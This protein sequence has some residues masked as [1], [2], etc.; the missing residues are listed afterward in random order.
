MPG[1]CEE[2]LSRISLYLD[3]ELAEHLC[4]ELERHLAECPDCHVVFHTT[5]RTIELYRRYGRT[6][7]PAEA[8]ERLF[9]VLRL[10]DLLSRGRPGPRR[11]PVN[12]IQRLNPRTALQPSEMRMKPPATLRVPGAVDGPDAPSL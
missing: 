9:R 12:R 6:P 5:R 8:R 1:R 2:W 11:P 4:R 3:G 7:M 10:E